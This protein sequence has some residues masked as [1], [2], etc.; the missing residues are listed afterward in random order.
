MGSIKLLY[1]PTIMFFISKTGKVKAFIKSFNT[2]K[3]VFIIA[4]AYII[5][6]T[7]LGGEPLY[8]WDWIVSFLEV[9]I[10]PCFIIGFMNS[11][12]FGS[13]ESM[14]RCLLVVGAVAT[15]ISMLCIA[16]PPINDF[17]RTYILHITSDM[18][19][20]EHSFRGFGISESLSSQ[21]G[22][23][24]GIMVILG[25]MFLKSNRWFLYFLPFVLLSAFVNARTGVIVAV[26][27]VVVY[28]VYNRNYSYSM[29]II[30]LSAILVA[31]FDAVLELVIPNDMTRLWIT[32][33]I[34]QMDAVMV[35]GV[36]GSRQTD[37]LFGQMIILPETPEKWI[38]GRGFN[39]RANDMGFDNSDVGFI[40]QLNYGGIIYVI[41]LVSLILYATLRLFRSKN[42]LFGFFFLIVFVI[43]NIKTHYLL[44][45][46]AFRIMMFTY[47]VLLLNSKVDGVNKKLSLLRNRCPNIGFRYLFLFIYCYG[48]YSNI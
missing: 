7:L 47:Y 45:S 29:V 12:G 16:F 8:L 22:Y 35:E 36:E 5:F 11:S 32:D 30:A 24:Q 38:I 9:M 44:N 34:E 1:I 41:I 10:V 19:A 26:V 4:L 6:R 48:Y 31:N 40:Q 42:K 18:R 2:E 23:V 14:T 43:I 13:L 21:Y 15:I 28:L 3:T 33:F 17:V 25:M 20:F 46:G 37:K 27:G 39:L